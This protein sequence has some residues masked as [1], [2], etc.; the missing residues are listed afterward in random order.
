MIGKST[1]LVASIVGCVSIKAIRTISYAAVVG[2]KGEP[3]VRAE[4]YTLTFRGEAQRQV[5]KLI[6]DRCTCCHTLLR[7]FVEVRIGGVGALDFALVSC[8]I[9]YVWVRAALHTNPVRAV[10]ESVHFWVG[11]ALSNTGQG[12]GIG[13][14]SGRA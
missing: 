6:N 1:I 8:V 5:R 13:E 10:V 14:S 7:G 4:I 11:M 3:T 2:E 9:S 12:V